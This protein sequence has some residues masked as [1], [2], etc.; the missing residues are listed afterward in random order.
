VQSFH[1]EG[2]TT[3]MRQSCTFNGLES[4]PALAGGHSPDAT[5][6]SDWVGSNIQ[7]GD[8]IYWIPPSCDPPEQYY[9]DEVRDRIECVS[10][11]LG[12]AF[13]KAFVDYDPTRTWPFPRP[14]A[15]VDA[16]RVATANARD[17]DPCGRADL[18]EKVRVAC[19][20][21][22]SAE[23]NRSGEIGQRDVGRL[24]M[25]CVSDSDWMYIAAIEPGADPEISG[26]WDEVDEFLASLTSEPRWK[27]NTLMRRAGPK[28]WASII[29]GRGLVLAD[30]H[31]IVPPIRRT[32][33]SVSG[34]LT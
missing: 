20:V 17:T 7:V 13:W 10:W 6:F 9:M 15:V 27:I 12:L 25:A 3:E 4:E 33:T 19:A 11:G 21:G 26:T 24:L 22:I 29:R 8:R 5:R 14:A 23:F 28:W 1:I 32:T 30:D 2:F 31:G 34:G 16:L 18:A